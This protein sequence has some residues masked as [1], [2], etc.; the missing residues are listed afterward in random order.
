M[1]E[2]IDYF[3]LSISNFRQEAKLLFDLFKG[4]ENTKR[5]KQPLQQEKIDQQALDEWLTQPIVPP[6]LVYLSSFISV[7]KFWLSIHTMHQCTLFWNRLC[8]VSNTRWEIE[9]N[10]LWQQNL[11]SSRMQ[12]PQLKAWVLMSIYIMPKTLMFLLTSTFW[13]TLR[14]AVSW[15]ASQVFNWWWSY[16][17]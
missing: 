6:S 16:P 15:A 13:R 11:R 5:S 7:S 2:L 10:W 3:R 12:I 9:G 8:I 17:K 14:Q 4:Q 1:L